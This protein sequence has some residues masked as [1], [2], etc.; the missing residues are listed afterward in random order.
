MTAPRFLETRARWPRLGMIRMG[1]MEG[2]GRSAHPKE[3]AWFVLPDSLREK[4]GEQPTRLPVMFPSDDV[5]RCLEVRYEKRGASGKLLIVCEGAEGQ[6]RTFNDDGSIADS[7]CRKIDREPCECGARARGHLNVILPEGGLGI[8]WLLLGG[9][10]RLADIWNEL[11]LY[12][13]TIGRLTNV[14]F[15]IVREPAEIT[16]VTPKG[17]IVRTGWPTHVRVAMAAQQA[18]ALHGVDVAALPGGQVIKHALPPAEEDEDDAAPT[19]TNGK[20]STEP[21]AYPPSPAN[22]ARPEP[23]VPA[24]VRPDLPADLVDVSV[25]IGEAEKCGVSQDLYDRYLRAVYGW[26]ASDITDA[27]VA[28]EIAAF[29]ALRTEGERMLHKS[30]LIRKLNDALKKK[31]KP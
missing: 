8:Y 31:A 2:T 15:E 24:P 26:G 14:V 13:A 17:R 21:A 18:F 25:C 29:R 20:L 1:V 7:P 3:V 4:Y 9:E 30:F 10:G 19:E 28:K 12:K 23:E 6:C 16:V 11:R 27:A 22:L 5:D